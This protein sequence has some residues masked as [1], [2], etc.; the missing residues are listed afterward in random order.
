MQRS[1]LH[2][3]SKRDLTQVFSCE[4]T[5]FVRTPSLHN[6][7][8]N[9]NNFWPANLFWM[10]D[11]T[12]VFSCEFTKFVRTPSLENNSNN[13]N[14][15]WPANLFWMAFCSSYCKTAKIFLNLIT[16]L[17][18]W[19]AVQAVASSEKSSGL[20]YS[21]LGILR[22]RSFPLNFGKFLGTRFFCRPLLLLKIAVIS[23]LISNKYFSLFQLSCLTYVQI[24]CCI[25]QKRKKEKKMKV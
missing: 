19:K 18:V 3:Y 20:V 6:N 21:N 17:K 5:K 8:N 24:S 7:S 1:G 22:H 16:W 15:F 11:L 23:L 12:Q 9:C 2:F 14:N 25:S 13:Y 4:F 10:W